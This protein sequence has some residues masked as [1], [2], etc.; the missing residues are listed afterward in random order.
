MSTMA[1]RGVDFRLQSIT[2]LDSDIIFLP[3]TSTFR[4]FLFLDSSTPFSLDVIIQQP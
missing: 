4:L 2:T 1:D 3:C